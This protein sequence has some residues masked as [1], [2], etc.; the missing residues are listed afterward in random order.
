MTLP[1]NT[2]HPADQ[3]GGIAASGVGSANEAN[4]AL[5]ASLQTLIVQQPFFKGLN[6]RQLHLLAESALLMN[7]ESGQAILAEGSPANRFYLI[8]EGKVAL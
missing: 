1:E 7:F 6:S 8:L 4:D 2:I 5:V 3:P